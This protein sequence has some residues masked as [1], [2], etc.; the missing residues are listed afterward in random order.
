ML[1]DLE[2]KLLRVVFNL[3]RNEWV[4]LDI[5]RIAHLSVRSQQQVRAALNS[6]WRQGYLEHNDGKSRVVYSR[7]KN[8]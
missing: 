2:R 7:E 4:R 6:L 1:S 8:W 3:N 5:P